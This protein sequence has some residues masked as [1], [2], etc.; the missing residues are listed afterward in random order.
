MPAARYWRIV[1][2]ETFAL[3][4]LVLSEIAC[5]DAT[6]TRVDGLA[7]ISSALPPSSGLLAT[8]G[9]GSFSSAVQWASADVTKPG[10]AVVWD[11]GTAQDVQKIAVAGPGK[12]EFPYLFFVQYSSDALVWSTGRQVSRID[13]PG[14][15]VFVE[16]FIFTGDDDFDKVGLLLHMDGSAGSSTIVDSGPLARAVTV[17]GNTVLSAVQSKF[18]GVSA[19]FDGTGDYITAPCVSAPDISW[20]IEFFAMGDGLPAVEA[21]M[22]TL[23]TSNLVL[24]RKTDGS[25]FISLQGNNYSGACGSLPAGVYKHIAIVKKI[26]VIYV[27]VEGVQTYSQATGPLW[28]AT[29]IK[30]GA[31]DATVNA[32]FKGWVDEFRMS[33][34]LARYTSSP[35]TTP[36]TSFPVDAVGVARR[37]TDFV[38]APII[39]TASDPGDVV[40]FG[41]ENVKAF[42]D[43]EDGG[44][45]R[46]VGTTKEKATPSNV[47]IARRVRLLNERDG[48][49]VRESWSDAAGNYSFSEIKGGRSYSIISYD[50]LGVYQAVIADNQTPEL[51]P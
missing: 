23:G 13:Y 6:S 16:R 7:T 44:W 33:E 24:S 45:Y 47:P 49:M 39:F 40:S 42:V 19:Y 34:G 8:L 46:I 20:T 17:F 30:L 15:S 2:V 25:L 9:D 51:M 27:Y 38:D 10:F 18:G 37:V 28:D 36:S 48:R 11:F 32:G 22:L 41:P 5:Y 35:F 29:S 50:H 31:L 1:G 3:G 12:N 4:D 26:N 14:A 43:L 21:R